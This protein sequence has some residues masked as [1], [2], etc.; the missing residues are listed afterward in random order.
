MRWLT[1]VVHVAT[2]STFFAT[3]LVFV[4]VSFLG[5]FFF[6]RAFETGFPDGDRKR[7][8]LA[9][10]PVADPRLLA[11][12]PRQGGLPGRRRS[13]WRRGAPPACSSTAGAASSCS[14]IGTFAAAM[15]RPHV[16]LIVV[17]ALVAA[18]L[19]RRSD[20]DPVGRLTAKVLAL[21]VIVV[22]GAILSSATAEFLNLEN[23]GVTEIDDG[24][25]HHR[26]A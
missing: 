5:V 23:L 3:F 17:I 1:G 15:V 19:L 16:A 25:Q 8:A 4:F 21:T 26:R 18:L 14:A 13:A 24:P 11:V 9:R 2:D 20:V 10:P 6:Y 22:A 7:Y 12:E